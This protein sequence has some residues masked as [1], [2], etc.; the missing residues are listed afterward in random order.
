MSK[1][2]LSL[3]YCLL[4]T[5]FEV[6][7]IDLGGIRLPSLPSVPLPSLPP[8]S[9]PA[10]PPLS[11]PSLPPL[12]RLPSIPLPQ[13]PKGREVEEAFHHNFTE[14]LNVISMGE[15]GRNRDRERANHQQESSSQRAQFSKTLTEQEL[16]HKMQ[17][18]ATYQRQSNEALQEIQL[19]E[20][21]RDRLKD[22]VRSTDI[23]ILNQDRYLSA[24]LRL[25][26]LA[27]EDE[28]VYSHFQQ[29]H[30]KLKE[31]MELGMEEVSDST[32]TDFLTLMDE[33]YKNYHDTVKGTHLLRSNYIAMVLGFSSEEDAG[34]SIGDAYRSNLENLKMF[35]ELSLQWINEEIQSKQKRSEIALKNVSELEIE[36]NILRPR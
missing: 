16:N 2:I 21:K 13:F 25:K 27:D 32:T 11:L 34:E 18:K 7:A 24:L 23:V 28:A 4:C 10:P 6:H 30:E 29:A 35:A 1:F 9:L 15:I 12:P 31:S 36:I 14:A 5:G 33:L 20:P 3:T 26:K 19:L 8:P 17:L 22:L